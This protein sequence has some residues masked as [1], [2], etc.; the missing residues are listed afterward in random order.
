[1]LSQVF[2]HPAMITLADYLGSQSSNIEGDLIEAVMKEVAFFSNNRYTDASQDIIQFAALNTQ[3]ILRLLRGGE[4]GSFEFIQQQAQKHATQHFPL[5]ALLQAYK[6]T[7]KIYIQWFNKAVAFAHLAK[8]EAHEVRLSLVDFAIE[9]EDEITAIAIPSYIDQ[10]RFQAEVAGDHRSELLSILLDGYDETDGKIAKILRDAG[11]LDRRQSFCIALAQSV[12]PAEMLNTTRARRMAKSI[13]LILRQSPV[14]HL[15]DIRDNRVVILFSHPRRSSG[16]TSPNTTLAKQLKSDL[17][18]VGNAALIGVSN[19]VPSTAAIP[20][21]WQEAR[22]ALEL[23]NVS[24]RVVQLSQVPV[25]RLLLHLAG[26][27][28]LKIL[29]SWANQLFL[30]DQQSNGKLSATLKAYARANMNALKAAHRLSVHPNT[31]YMRMQKIRDSTGLDPKSYQ[32]LTELLIVV[33]IKARAQ[34]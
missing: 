10:T 4:T 14:G 17:N 33:D 34:A 9:Y 12:D 16:W 29:P 31:I 23:A 28:F 21:A 6:S 1:M 11:F 20:V 8:T 13:G 25:D 19:D 2:K 7:R 3:E 32:A 24:N 22:I 27:Q 30:I 15:I 26:E 5:E 18:L